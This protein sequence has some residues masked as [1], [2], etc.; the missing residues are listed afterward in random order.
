MGKFVEEF[1]HLSRRNAVQRQQF[2]Y[3]LAAD[4]R[5]FEAL[6]SAFARSLPLIPDSNIGEAPIFV[7]GLPNTGIS[8]VE[9][10]LSSHS[11]VHSGGAFQALPLAI[12]QASG[13]GSLELLGADTVEAV[14]GRS[15][16]LIGEEYINCAAQVAAPKGKRVTDSFP[17]NF[18]YLGWIVAAL[19]NATIVNLRRGTMDSVWNNFKNIVPAD[20]AKYRW[21][22][23][24]MDTARYVLMYQR[25]MAFWR[26]RFPGRIHEVIY[27]LLV[28]DQEA[29]IRRMLTHCGLSWDDACLETATTAA[30]HA[31]ASVD[32]HGSGSW[33]DFQDQ[34]GEV[35][36]FFTENGIPLD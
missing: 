4:E 8:Q 15:A 9:R 25:I 5:S 33:R 36:D 23:D 7:L 14:A 10:I 20:A 30:P 28:T 12:K 27:D 17:L 26:Q 16:R 35:I 32:S 6:R 11:G 22:T 24:I 19:P 13:T 18:L 31:D 34:L 29:Q 3:D 1:S 2:P 21:S